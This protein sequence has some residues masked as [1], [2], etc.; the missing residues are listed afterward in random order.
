MN[1]RNMSY[2]QAFDEILTHYRSSK[3]M[4]NDRK[5]FCH[6]RIYRPISW[7]LTV[8]SVKS[9]ITA[10]QMTL[11]RMILILVTCAVLS[12]GDSF[13]LRFGALMFFVCVCLDFVDGNIARLFE[14]SNLFG[15]LIDGFVD[16]LTRLIF[17]FIALGYS[18]LNVSRFDEHTVLVL[19]ALITTSALYLD[20][21][22]VRMALVQTEQK[23]TQLTS[24]GKPTAAK[25]HRFSQIRNL[26][27][28]IPDWA[29]IAWLIICT[30]N[31]AFTDWL[32]AF[33]A[34]FF[35]VLGPADILALS[36]RQ[37]HNL[38]TRREV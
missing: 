30:F 3:K 13:N 21:F 34:V 1:F 20:L 11:F 37:K 10:N 18:K 14:S 7:P 36:L 23:L 24:L 27:N 9:G 17:L 35:A 19:G 22:R 12:V 32:L 26:L 8:F 38:Q 31:V 25:P 4:E 15:K 5:V 16:S 6:F 28:E 2:R 29:P 33:Y